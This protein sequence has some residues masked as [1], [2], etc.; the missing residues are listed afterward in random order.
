MNYTHYSDT[1]NY[2]DLKRHFRPLTKLVTR[3]LR[4]VRDDGISSDCM[5]LFGF[6]FGGRLV[7]E[8]AMQYG[9]GKI[10]AI[11]SKKIYWN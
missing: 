5:F 7:I 6:S 2:L 3:K 11:D 8:A 9:P 1:P 4:Q 10:N